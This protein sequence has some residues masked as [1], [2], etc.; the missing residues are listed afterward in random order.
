MRGQLEQLQDGQHDVVDVAEARGLRLLRVVQTSRPVQHDV[1]E[2][3]VQ[4]TG[5]ADGPR[6]VG[7][8]V[9]EQTIEDGTVLSHVD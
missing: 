8:D 7:S 4:S 2:T 5:A 6:T 3:L 9:V 1:G